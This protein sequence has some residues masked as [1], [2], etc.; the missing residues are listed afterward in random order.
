M[1]QS[2]RIWG[3]KPLR[4]KGEVDG[5]KNSARGDWEEASTCDVSK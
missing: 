2:P 3:G 1:P 5:G 4:S